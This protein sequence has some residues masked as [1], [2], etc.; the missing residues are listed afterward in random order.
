MILVDRQKTIRAKALIELLKRVAKNKE[1]LE[2]QTKWK[3]MVAEDKIEEKDMVEYIYTKLGGLVRTEQE[4]KV[5][6]K[7]E[8]E[9]KKEYSKKKK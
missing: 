2:I 8:V 3:G 6:E 7:K 4:Q 1:E 5:A 9:I